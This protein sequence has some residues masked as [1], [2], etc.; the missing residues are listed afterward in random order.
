MNPG[1]INY[2]V[3]WSRTLTKKLIT[4][5]VADYRMGSTDP[6]D[7]D[8]FYE[9]LRRLNHGELKGRKGDY[10]CGSHQRRKGRP[11]LCLNCEAEYADAQ[12]RF[13]ELFKKSKKGKPN[14]AAHDGVT[15]D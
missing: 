12:A 15:G 2:R 10:R 5:H 1:D 8:A 3:Q 11:P 4:D 14:D 9:F 6:A 13:P 7:V